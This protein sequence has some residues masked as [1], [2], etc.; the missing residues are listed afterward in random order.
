MVDPR[1]ADVARRAVE[2]G[3]AAGVELDDD[4]ALW[5]LGG[6]RPRAA[7][8]PGRPE[9]LG[10]LLEAATNAPHRRA[11]GLHYTPEELAAGVV[12]RAL[13]GH[14]EPSVCD[15]SCGG[16]ALLLAAARHQAQ[17]GGDPTEIVG[18]L[19]GAD[20][21]PLAVATTEVA[22]TLWAGRRPP[23]GN[24]VVA[25]TLW[26]SP[27]W[28]PFDV[29]VGNPPFLSQLDAAT[30]R[31]SADAD[32]WRARFGAAVQ[33]YTDPSALFLLAGCLLTRVGGTV[34]MVQ[35]QSVMGARDA[36]GV[37]EAV[38]AKAS[39]REVWVPT[40]RAFAAAV[41]VCVPVLEVGG[42]DGGTPVWGAHLARAFGVPEVDLE[43]GATVGDEAVTAA[44][45]RAE[46][47][48]IAPHVR[49]EE[50]LP[51]GRPLLTTGLV[52]LGRSAWGERPARVAGR[53]WERPVV[54]SAAL[55][56]R[57]AAW[58]DRSAAPKLIIASQTRV[59]EVIVDADGRFVPGV[60][61]VVAWAPA[62]RL[63]ALAAALASPPVTAWAA[64]R[65]AGTALA[66]GAL[67]LTAALVRDAPLPIDHDAWRA[68]TDALERRDLLRFADAMT[69]A[70]RCAPD[71]A[72]WWLDRVGSAWSEPA[73]SR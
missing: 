12:E 32:R 52:D 61:L 62:A 28:A 60:P 9:E 1:A 23:P 22:L 19:W 6:G 24:L 67:K 44:A 7:P 2:I 8:A 14:R 72:A 37:R 11:R 42:G 56:G 64:A 25:D 13:A 31:S 53:R 49:E 58:A 4:L 5:A 65:A 43:P 29:I 50:D 66:P 69:S 35:P 54:D 27:A 59:V 48:G 40:G 34:A 10:L 38:G 47:Y 46:Y 33:A 63:W 70:Y 15:P 51:A 41:D 36:A 68:G 17:R 30:T 20:I 55:E 16:G 73:P 26:A 39:L 71:V 21:D 18:R 45:F 57:A 3:L